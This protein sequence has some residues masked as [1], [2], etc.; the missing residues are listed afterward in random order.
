MEETKRI[1]LV[2]EL[3]IGLSCCASL[4]CLSKSKDA[5]YECLG[6]GYIKDVDIIRKKVFIISPLNMQ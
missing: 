2:S 3:D 1:K 5:P 4:V 6:F